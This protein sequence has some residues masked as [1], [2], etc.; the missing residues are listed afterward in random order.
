MQIMFCNKKGG[1]VYFGFRPIKSFALNGP[2]G[3][4][5]TQRCILLFDKVSGY[6]LKTYAELIHKYLSRYLVPLKTNFREKNCVQK[7][8]SHHLFYWLYWPFHQ[9]AWKM[10]NEHPREKYKSGWEGFCWSKCTTRFIY[11]TPPKNT[12]LEPGLWVQHCAIQLSVF[13]TYV[14]F[15]HEQEMKNLNVKQVE[16]WC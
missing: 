12:F 5:S 14:Y 15:I 10:R 13:V 2:S 8:V 16:K 6:D 1:D 3:K 4:R 9:S 7:F 11:L